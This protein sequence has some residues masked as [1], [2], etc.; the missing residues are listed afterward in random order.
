M[1][2]IYALLQWLE[3]R[4]PQVCVLSNY[5]SIDVSAFEL[6]SSGWSKDR[7]AFSFNVTGSEL[8]NRKLEE[9]SNLHAKVHR[10][11]V[12]TLFCIWRRF[13]EVSRF[14]AEMLVRYSISRN[15]ETIY[16]LRVHSELAN[17]SNVI[18]WSLSLSISLKAFMTSLSRSLVSTPDN[19]KY[20]LL[21]GSIFSM[22]IF[23]ALFSSSKILINFL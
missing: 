8:I 10:F 11:Y 13:S 3:R 19:I 14:F 21:E 20:K 12:S 1:L 6:G 2:K 22:I 7:P 17:S 16:K 4:P 5:W 23:K 15:C 18:V 9:K